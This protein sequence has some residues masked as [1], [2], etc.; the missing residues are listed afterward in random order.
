MILKKNLKKIKL[1]SQFSLKKHSSSLSKFLF[2]Y[3]MNKNEQPIFE[4]PID[5]IEVLQDPLDFY[6]ALE[7]KKKIP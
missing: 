5:K 7:V 4:I 3:Q 1:K 6:A 2:D